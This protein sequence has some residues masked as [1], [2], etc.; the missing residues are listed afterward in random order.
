MVLGVLKDAPGAAGARIG[1]ITSRRVGGAVERN[2][3]R[4]RLREIFRLERLRV[5]PGVWLVLVARRQAVR[6]SFDQLQAEWRQLAKRGGILED[7]AIS[8]C[9]S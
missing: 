9:S 6:A 8:P 2:R 4:R 1:I 3:V 5:T 7:P